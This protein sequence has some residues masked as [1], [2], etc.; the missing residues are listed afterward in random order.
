[1]L[2]LLSPVR[3]KGMKVKVSSLKIPFAIWRSL[4]LLTDVYGW[5][6]SGGCWG[7]FRGKH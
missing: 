4:L 3:L 7:C 5:E 2:V 1:M 6:V